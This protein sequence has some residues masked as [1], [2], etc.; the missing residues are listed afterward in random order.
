MPSRKTIH[1]LGGGQW[2]VPTIELAKSLGFRVLVTD[3][4][5]E[6]PGYALADEYA[7]MD[8]TDRE[9]TL[10]IANAASMASSAIPRTWACRP[11]PMW[12]RNWGSPASGM[13][14]R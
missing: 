14:S 6:R 1:I 9:G 10:R 5:P 11:W 12:P 13:R 7:V 8:I 2:Q 3:M 4:Y